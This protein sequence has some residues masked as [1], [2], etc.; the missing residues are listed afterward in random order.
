MRAIRALPVM[1]KPVLLIL[2]QEHSSPGRVGQV[3]ASLGYPL[4]VRR[5]RFG[6]P[7]P[8][9]MDEHAG[10]VI[11]GGPQSA[12]DA[13]DFIKRETDWSGVPL[14]DDKPYLMPRSAIIRSGRPPPGARSAP[15]GP[16][17]STSGTARAS[18]C[19][20]APSCW[21]KATLSRCRRSATAPVMRCS[22]TRKSR[23]R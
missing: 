10:A 19:R 9:T 12:N 17:A 16:I 13:D 8:E 14:R 6:D 1:L 11:F 20:T 15:T 18:T 3:L 5:P 4:D 21:P 7:L 22:S 23:T 2:H